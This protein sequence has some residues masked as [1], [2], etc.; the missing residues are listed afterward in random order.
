[1]ADKVKNR[2]TGDA[3]LTR[4]A[5]TAHF[6]DM[7]INFLYKSSKAKRA[8]DTSKSLTE[9]YKETVGEYAAAVNNDNFT[10]SCIAGIMKKFAQAKM[11]LTNREVIK[12][13]LLLMIPEEFYKTMS[14]ENDMYIAIADVMRRIVTQTAVA[15]KI[16]WHTIII[17][18]H[19]HCANEVMDALAV[20]IENVQTKIADDFLNQKA[21]MFNRE[22]VSIDV[23]EHTRR[24]C[25][26]LRAEYAR[27]AREY[28]ALKLENDQCKLVIS[29]S[30]EE[31][32]ALRAKTEWLSQ[33][34]SMYTSSTSGP[35]TGTTPQLPAP[36]RTPDAFKV[37]N[38]FSTANLNQLQPNTTPPNFGNLLASPKFAT[39]RMSPK[40][41]LQPVQEEQTLIDVADDTPMTH[42]IKQNTVKT[43]PARDLG[44]AVNVDFDV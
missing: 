35:N 37:D 3:Y 28:A 1:M 4:E 18:D 40:V 30:R 26:Q 41:E 42:F 2:L 34:L 39:P 22:M 6:T 15:V 8:N 32:D 11:N 27:L 21:K 33:Q 5:I 16:K 10:S 13:I 25:M 20:I 17:D 12:R 19:D 7:Y 24:E 36:V 38:P 14:S 44:R 29:K 31:R 9:A 43:K 23:V